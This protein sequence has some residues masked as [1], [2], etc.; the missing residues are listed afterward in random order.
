MFLKAKEKPRGSAPFAQVRSLKGEHDQSIQDMSMIHSQY[1]EFLVLKNG[2]LVAA[3]SSSGINL[4]LFSSYEQTD[5]F[6]DYGAFLISN[7][8]QANSEDIQF[9]DM[10]VPVDFNPYLIGWKKRYIDAVDRGDPV[11][12]HL[13]ASYIDH[14][15]RISQKSEMTTKE[16]LI[17]LR[18][19]LKDQSIDSLEHAA[20]HLLE[21]S[22]DFMK[23]L[24][25]TFERY[26]LRCRLLNANEY[27]D[28]LY[29]FM[30]F[31]K[32]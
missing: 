11:K 7:F 24:E 5:L 27:K 15:E 2:Y 17:I 26:E 3:L 29:L 13:I 20:K 19:E 9:N 12:Q 21:R 22:N 23:A 1:H 14:Y 31:N 4:E 6:D 28:K 18:E 16:H 25:S 30:N 10:T 32:R 8:A